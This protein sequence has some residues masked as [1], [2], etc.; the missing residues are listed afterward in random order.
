MQ[1]AAGQTLDD[2]TDGKFGCRFGTEKRPGRC[3]AAVQ[4]FAGGDTD[5][6]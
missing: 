3:L 6:V 1:A 4:E 5:F 2:E